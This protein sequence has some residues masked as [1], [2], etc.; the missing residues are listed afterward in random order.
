MIKSKLKILS[1]TAA[2]KRIKTADVMMADMYF[3]TNI[4][5]KLLVIYTTVNVDLI[6]RIYA[7]N[8]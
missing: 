6:N 8:K 4:L 1:F 5:D 3:H 7:K 2:L